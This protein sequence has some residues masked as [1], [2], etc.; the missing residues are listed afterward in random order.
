MPTLLSVLKSILKLVTSSLLDKR[1][2]PGSRA[3]VGRIEYHHNFIH[4][5][6]GSIQHLN[7]VQSEDEEKNDD[8]LFPEA[9]DDIKQ[10]FGKNKVQCLNNS[11]TDFFC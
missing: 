1:S 8:D 7:Q 2:L 5:E 11:N 9:P 10:I 6:P 4:Q 3:D